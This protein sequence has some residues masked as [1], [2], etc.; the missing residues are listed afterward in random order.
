MFVFLEEAWIQLA[1]VVCMGIVLIQ[2]RLVSIVTKSVTFPI[3]L[4]FQ[5]AMCD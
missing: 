5:V 1:I 3:G 2:D 4:R